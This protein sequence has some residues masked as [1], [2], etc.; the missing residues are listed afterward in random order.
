[1][2]A[3]CLAF[4]PFAPAALQQGYT[5]RPGDVVIADSR[6]LFGTTGGYV[7]VRHLDGS[8]ETLASGPPLVSPTDVIVDRD[9]AVL[10][11]NY[12]Y[13]SEPINGIY[14]IDPATGA[15]T[16]VDDP[17]MV[18][19]DLFQF[20]RDTNGD[21]V[22]ADGFRGLARVDETGAITWFSPPTAGFDVSIGIAL[23]YD[24]RVLSSEAPNYWSGGGSTIGRVSSVD[25]AG[26]RALVGMD[27]VVMPFPNGLCLD[28]DGS[29][30]LTDH[31]PT[32]SLPPHHGLV[33]LDRA[34]LATQLEWNGLDQPTDV[35]VAGHGVNLIADPGDESVLIESPGRFLRRLVSE[36]DDGLPYNQQPVDRPYGVA[37][38]PWLWLVTP[39]TVAIGQQAAVEVRS[40]PAFAGARVV[41][42]IS[43]GNGPSP[44]ATWWPG[45]L[46]SSHLDLARA[47]AFE[48]TLSAQG[49]TVFAAAVPNDPAL[50]GRALQLQAFLPSRRLL[51]NPVSLPVR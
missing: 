45:D 10:F 35:E 20:C 41:L 5:L 37:V 42:A 11:S 21:L 22:V 38:V 31:A 4:L 36:H 9:G 3:A 7:R 50:Q 13:Q 33:R 44:L 40:L 15:V 47:V 29:I 17:Q 8:V 43:L 32:T 23:D 30:L 48:Q 2:L 18:L 14:R 12:K 19:D 28:A 46:Q 24:G 34:G 25:A 1:M 27:A 39:N 51:S 16:Q 6:P 26:Q 49:T